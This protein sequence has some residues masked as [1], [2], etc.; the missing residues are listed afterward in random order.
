MAPSAAIV[1]PSTDTVRVAPI[2]LLRRPATLNSILMPRKCRFAINRRK[3][4]NV[5][6]LAPIEAAVNNSNGKHTESSSYATTVHPV[7][8]LVAGPN[9]EA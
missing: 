8:R 4:L 9:G 2:P 1:S 5:E 3:G 6:M 7:P